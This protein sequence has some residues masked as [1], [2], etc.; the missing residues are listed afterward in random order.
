MVDENPEIPIWK[1]NDFGTLAS[2]AATGIMLIKLSGVEDRYV[3]SVRRGIKLL[4]FLSRGRELVE[5]DTLIENSEDID[6]YSFF[7]SIYPTDEPSQE[8]FNETV[9]EGMELVKK[10]EPLVEEP[11]R[12]N[13]VKPEDM[14]RYQD[15]FNRVCAQ[16]I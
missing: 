10:L 14:V 7:K 5:G 9:N 6:I 15:V 3:T 1:Y 8:R 2:H 16:L 11:D 12:F 4:Y 13:E